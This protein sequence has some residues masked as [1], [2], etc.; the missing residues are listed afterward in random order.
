MANQVTFRLTRVGKCLRHGVCRHEVIT[1]LATCRNDQRYVLSNNAIQLH[2]AS[3]ITEG[4]SLTED[5]SA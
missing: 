2:V 5:E 4:R 1:K 3:R